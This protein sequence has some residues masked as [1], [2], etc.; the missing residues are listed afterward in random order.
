MLV[1]GDRVGEGSSLSAGRESA[2]MERGESIPRI[3]LMVCCST[4]SALPDQEGAEPW[5]A[6]AIAAS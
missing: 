1:L 4:D 3:A 5:V 6:L 2:D